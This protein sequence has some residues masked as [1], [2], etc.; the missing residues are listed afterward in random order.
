MCATTCTISWKRFDFPYGL[1][2]LA[3]LRC[4][5]TISHGI[6][7]VDRPRQIPS[8]GTLGREQTG[9]TVCTPSQWIHPDYGR[10]TFDVFNSAR[11]RVPAVHERRFSGPNHLVCETRELSA[12]P[13]IGMARDPVWS[14]RMQTGSTRHHHVM[15][16]MVVLARHQT[17]EPEPPDPARY[18]GIVTGHRQDRAVV[19]LLDLDLPAFV[20]R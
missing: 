11:R 14:M 2:R 18:R 3:G 1:V 16:S 13:P 7:D 15:L 8:F 5:R 20:L 9:S 12:T 17:E 10:R 4:R 19:A 6:P